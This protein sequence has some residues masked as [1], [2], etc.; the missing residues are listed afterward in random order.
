MLR[1]LE[2][3]QLEGLINSKEDAI[4]YVLRHF[5]NKKHPSNDDGMEANS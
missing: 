2:D 5:G 4:E 3:A 1:S